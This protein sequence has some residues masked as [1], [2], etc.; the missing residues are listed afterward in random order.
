M[1]CPDDPPHTLALP[2]RIIKM[3]DPTKSVSPPLQRA[4]IGIGVSALAV[5][6]GVA[7]RRLMRGPIRTTPPQPVEEDTDVLFGKVE[8]KDH[9]DEALLMD[10]PVVRK[11]PYFWMRDDERKSERVLHHLKQENAYTNYMTLGLTGFAQGI[12]HELLSHYKE[13][14]VTVPAKKGR[15]VYYIRTEKGKSYKYYCRKRAGADGM[16]E[17]EEHV[18]LDVNQ[19]AKASQHCD[20]GT[21][22]VSPEGNVLAYSVDVLGY[23]T[24]DVR[25][26]DLNTGKLLEEDT[27][28][29]TT[30]GME[31]GKDG[32]EVY[33]QTFDD[34]HRP[35]KVWRHRMKSFGNSTGADEDVCLYTENHNEFNLYASKSKSGRILMISSYAST[36]S[37]H[38]FVDLDYPEEGVRLF[39][40]REP[41][42]LYDVSHAKDDTFYVTTNR[43]GAR[44]FKIMETTISDTTKWADYLPYDP[45]RKVDALM[46]CRDFLVMSGRENGYR[47]LWVIPDH[48]PSKMYKLPLEEKAHVVSFGINLEYNTPTFRY[49]Y[50]SMTTPVQFHEY[51]IKKKRSKLLK[52]TEVPNYDRSIYKTERLEARSPDGTIVPMSLVYNLKAVRANGPNRLH[53]YGYGSYEISIDPSFSMAALPLLDRGVIFAIAHIRGGGEFGREWYEAARFETKKKTFEDFC[54]CAEKLVED[55]RTTPDLMSMEGRS[56]GGMLMGAVMNMR[57]DLFKA[58]LAGVPFV[59]VL[60]TMSDVSIPLTTGEWQEW[61]N[62][63]QQ[64]YF[65]AMKEYCPY[66]N[67]GEKPYPAT[68]ILTGLYDPRVLYSEPAKWVAK[69]RKYSTSGEPIL[70]KVDMSSGHFSASNR[71]TYLKERSFELAWVLRQVG[72]QDSPIAQ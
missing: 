23:E 62:P 9:G 31:W 39:K 13:T 68:L 63:H 1:T 20:I 46:C 29:G 27:I 25:F 8:G 65:D 70:L 10:P 72:A 14:D 19:L 50:S 49:H 24:Y 59:D 47:E 33:Y 44:N 69:L 51:D 34:S 11:D 12:Y 58:V 6:G 48:D 35:H 22:D 71:Y 55:K 18:I 17:G 43:D 7:L 3:A 57:P 37:E 53:L 30:G 41:N 2:H 38:R 5:L 61:G 66:T 60:N 54:A 42:V 56:A 52:E 64:K 4:I 15:F 40:E 28:K 32:S 16:G 36:V 67:V 45:Q 26:V 21:T